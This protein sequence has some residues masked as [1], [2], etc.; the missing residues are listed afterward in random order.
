MARRPTVLHRAP[1]AP[2]AQRG[3]RAG[4]ARGPLCDRPL[5]A[6]QFTPYGRRGAGIFVRGDVRGYPLFFM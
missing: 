2:F 5:G 4:V 1:P 3:F 6:L